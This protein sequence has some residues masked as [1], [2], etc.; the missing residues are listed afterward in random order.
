MIS[1]NELEDELEVDAIEG[2]ACTVVAMDAA[3]TDDARDAMAVGAADRGAE[4]L[5]DDFFG[6]VSNPPA[7]TVD[8]G[9]YELAFLSS[10]FLNA[11]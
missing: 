6:A 1:A 8:A 5:A 2:G 9:E 10:A 11:V 3:T 4:R 7:T